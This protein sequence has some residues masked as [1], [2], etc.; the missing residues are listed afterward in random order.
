MPKDAHSMVFAKDAN[1]R[2][3]F[4]N[5]ALIDQLSALND[6]D[7]DF[8]DVLG[9]MDSDLGINHGAY[10]ESDRQVLKSHFQMNVVFSDRIE[11][12]ES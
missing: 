5:E 8:A 11:L 9:K 2:F 7:L 12:N 4:A 3:V 6:T 1:R 10:L